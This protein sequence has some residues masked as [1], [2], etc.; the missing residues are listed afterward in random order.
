MT[1]IGLLLTKYVQLRIDGIFGMIVSIFMIFGGV[2]LIVENVKNLLGASLNN[3]TE[4]E[5]R[6]MLFQTGSLKD[7]LSTEYYDYGLGERTLYV[8]AVFTNEPDYDIIKKATSDAFKK[9]S[10]KIKFICEV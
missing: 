4:T 9:Y 7:I 10:I 8:N 3:S 6:N 5:I 2:K 1:V